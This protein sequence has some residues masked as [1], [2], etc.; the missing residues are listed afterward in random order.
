MSLRSSNLIRD[1]LVS[2]KLRGAS[3]LCQQMLFQTSI[4]VD[5][6]NSNIRLLTRVSVYLF[7]SSFHNVY[8]VY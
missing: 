6:S 8:L 4:P 3:E 1:L 7:I 5:P 2:S